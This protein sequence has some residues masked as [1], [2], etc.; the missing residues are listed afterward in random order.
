MEAGRPAEFDFPLSFTGP[1]GIGATPFDEVLEQEAPTSRTC[2]A[3][4]RPWRFAGCS[5]SSPPASP[6]SPR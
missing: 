1:D 3:M 5:A 6:S 4:T 2:R